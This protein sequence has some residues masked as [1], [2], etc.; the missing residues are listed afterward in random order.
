MGT[1]GIFK[2]PWIGNGN[3]LP[4]TGFGGC[5]FLANL[6]YTYV[7]TDTALT[8]TTDQFAGGA[9]QYTGFTAGR[10]V[11][12]PTATLITA[13]MGDDF[14]IGDSFTFIVSVVPAFALTWAAGAGVTLRGS[15]TVEAS[16]WSLVTITKTGANTYDWTVA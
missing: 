5:G 1:L 10:V 9:V 2:R 8:M 12:T 15:A 3:S 14:T 13:A 16:T 4:M 11:T 7:A 6:R